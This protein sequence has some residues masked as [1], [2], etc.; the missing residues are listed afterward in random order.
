MDK[1]DFISYSYTTKLLLIHDLYKAKEKY[2]KSLLPRLWYPI[3]NRPVFSFYYTNDNLQTKD[4]S[5]HM[6]RPVKILF[7]EQHKKHFTVKPG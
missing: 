4:S 3:F 1:H 6:Y 5:L 7:L 2:Q